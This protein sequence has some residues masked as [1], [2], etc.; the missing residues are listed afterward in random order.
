MDALPSSQRQGEGSEGE[1]GVFSLPLTVSEIVL[2]VVYL[3][4]HHNLVRSKVPMFRLSFW[5]L[6]PYVRLQNTPLTGA[7]DL[8]CQCQ[9]PLCV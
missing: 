5:A 4:D 7:T 6:S 8:S 2:H 9:A 1:E 3:K